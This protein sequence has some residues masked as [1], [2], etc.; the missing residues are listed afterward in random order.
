LGT[1]E[2]VAYG[3]AGG[4]LGANEESVYMFE[5]E[6]FGQFYI[7]EHL[8]TWNTEEREEALKYGQ[9]PGDPK[10]RDVNNDGQID[11]QDRIRAGHINPDLNL[12][13][14]TQLNYKNVQLSFNINAV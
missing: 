1:A 13:F 5:G 8:G 3:G 2:R 11:E 12:G 10:Y 9:L 14:N 6:R 7:W 4:G